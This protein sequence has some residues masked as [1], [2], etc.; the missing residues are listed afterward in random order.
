MKKSK[1]GIGFAPVGHYIVLVVPK[2]V[3]PKKLYLDKESVYATGENNKAIVSKPA[4]IEQVNKA[5]SIA[6]E[7]SLKVAAIGPDVIT[8]ELNDLIQ[9]TPTAKPIIIEMPNVE[10]NPGLIIGD[11]GKDMPCPLLY[12]VF[13]ETDIVVIMDND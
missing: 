6:L 11:D 1:S 12:W 10:D 13:R 5:S 9:I 2:S 4:W 3:Y 8:C 7:G